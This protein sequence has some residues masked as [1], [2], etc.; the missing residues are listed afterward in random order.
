MLEECMLELAAAFRVSEVNKIM[1]RG[2]W[3]A[4]GEYDC[5]QIRAAFDETLK[6]AKFWP[7]PAVVRSHVKVRMRD[8][9]PE[10]PVL[11]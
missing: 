11:R 6:V 2:F 10:L 3:K 5:D 9:F 8:L 4:V 1:I 7:T